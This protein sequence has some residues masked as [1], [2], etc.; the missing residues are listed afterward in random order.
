MHV[1]VYM[2]ICIY[3]EPYGFKVPKYGVCMASILE[4]RTHGF[5][6]SICI[7]VLGPLG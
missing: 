6:N 5:G 3:I 7:W 4:N 1:L 2:Y